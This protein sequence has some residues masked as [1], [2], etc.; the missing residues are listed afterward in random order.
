MLT[1]KVRSLI[2]D[3]P[4]LGRRVDELTKRLSRASPSDLDDMAAKETLEEMLGRLQPGDAKHGEAVFNSKRAACSA[5]HTVAGKGG[6]TGPDLSN[7]GGLRRRPDLLEAI[8]FPS[9][10]IV[11]SYET[12][13]VVMTD[14]RTAEGVIQRADSR[15]LVL[16]NSQREDTTIARDDIEQL[17]RSQLSIMPQG[18]HVNLNM[19]ELSDLLAY[20]ESLGKK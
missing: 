7:I 11:N 3:N 18:L 20:L 4:E 15:W 6:D 10:T 13:A 9:S 8:I 2:G 1:N 12:Y 14:G 16:R 5:C 19:N 17:Q